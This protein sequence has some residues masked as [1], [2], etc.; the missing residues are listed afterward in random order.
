ML[1]SVEAQVQARQIGQLVEAFDMADK[2]VIQVDFF[3]SAAEVWREFNAGD[4][5]LTE[6]YFLS[7]KY[8]LVKAQRK[9][10]GSFYLELRKPFEF[11]CRNG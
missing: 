1:D 4:V 8:A 11:Q 5:V 9:I 3:Q 10:L 2:V 7:R 6:A